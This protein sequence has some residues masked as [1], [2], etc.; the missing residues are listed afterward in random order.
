V[1]RVTAHRG[2]SFGQGSP[3]DL[4]DAIIPGSAQAV[5][6][7]ALNGYYRARP[8]AYRKALANHETSMQRLAGRHAQA[9]AAAHLYSTMHLHPDP[10]FA[11]L[12]RAAI[13]DPTTQLILHDWL[14]ERA[15]P[16][17]Y[18]LRS[19]RWNQ[20]KWTEPQLLDLLSKPFASRRRSFRGRA[21]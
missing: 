20:G 6:P 16:H 5:Q 17:A 1:G 14:A 19:K 3:W 18:E 8:E 9:V 13:A 21:L 15:F 2:T 11:G 10:G 7:P 4:A 12:V